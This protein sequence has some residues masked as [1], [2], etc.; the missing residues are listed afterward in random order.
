MLVHYWYRALFAHS[1]DRD[2][3]VLMDPIVAWVMFRS[4]KGDESFTPPAQT[5][6]WLAA[7]TFS[8]KSWGI[9]ETVHLVSITLPAACFW[10]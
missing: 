10:G 2:E 7:T 8:G 6:P 9:L 1:Y 4:W 3:Q 5:T